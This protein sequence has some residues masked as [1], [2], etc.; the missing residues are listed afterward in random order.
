MY[1]LTTGKIR[2][3]VKPQFLAGQSRPEDRHFVWAYTI[4]IEN[5]GE[6]TVT[7]RNRYW[8]ITDAAGKVQ[9]VRGPGVVGEQPVLR[10]GD[11]FQ[12]TSGCPLSTP[13]GFMVGSY[14][15]EYA[16]GRIFDVGIP[17]FS[18]DSPLDRHSLN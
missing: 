17:A 15:M 18:L 9:E 12:Y 4:T 8:K 1:E 10:P 2:V 16:D 11:S 6:E 14:G 7:L 13:S 3:L 5:H